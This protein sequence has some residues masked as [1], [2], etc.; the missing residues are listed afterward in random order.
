M[1][2]ERS[3]DEEEAGEQEAGES[4]EVPSSQGLRQALVVTDQPTEA[5]WSAARSIG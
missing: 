4:H 1:N 2:L 5:S 3:K